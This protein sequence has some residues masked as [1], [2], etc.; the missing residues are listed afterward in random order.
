[1]EGPVVAVMLIGGE[2]MEMGWLMGG[3]GRKI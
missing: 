3:W 2:G 1:M